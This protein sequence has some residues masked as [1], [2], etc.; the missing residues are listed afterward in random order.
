MQ[1][2]YRE[3]IIMHAFYPRRSDASRTNAIKFIFFYAC[4]FELA[5]RGIL[6]TDGSLLWCR[7]TATG[8]RVLDSVISHLVPLSGKNMIRLHLLVARR[9]SELYRLQ[10]EQMTESRYFLKEDITF[11]SWK[12]GTRYKVHRYDILKPDL[13]R[14]E[15]VLVYGRKPDPALFPLIILTGEGKLLKN[16]FSAREFRDRA[17]KRYKQLVKSDIFRDDQSV[18]HLRK[19]LVRTMGMQKTTK[20]Y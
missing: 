7:E 3:K 14:L 16:I 18:W 8:D 20:S 9:A 19:S 13:T 10:M 11:I 4:L 5:E 12:V 1:P 2:G 6:K 15:R 17:K